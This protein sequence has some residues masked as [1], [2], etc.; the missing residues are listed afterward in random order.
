MAQEIDWLLEPRSSKHREPGKQILLASRW[1]FVE[2]RKI[3][4]EFIKRWTSLRVK[5]FVG[6]SFLEVLMKRM[7]A[8]RTC[9][10][11]IKKKKKLCIIIVNE[12][13]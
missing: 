8:G 2:M 5:K 3:R 11:Q 6:E 7:R 12:C 9:P 4:G 1:K 13:G 10:F